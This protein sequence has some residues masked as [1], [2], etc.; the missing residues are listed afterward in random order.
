LVGGH[1]RGWIKGHFKRN[2]TEHGR[3]RPSETAKWEKVLICLSPFCGHND[4]SPV[5]QRADSGHSRSQFP[6]NRFGSLR[7]RIK[8]GIHQFFEL[9]PLPMPPPSDFSS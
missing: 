2:S 8:F 5:G 9:A 3:E 1:C 6:H 4:G 7:G